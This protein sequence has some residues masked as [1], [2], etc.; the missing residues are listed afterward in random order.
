MR[1]KL[2]YYYVLIVSVLAINSVNS[3]INYSANFNNDN[4]NWQSQI[5]TQSSVLPCDGTGA[6]IGNLYTYGNHINATS[7][8]IGISNGG[9]ISLS[10]KY[11]ILDHRTREVITN[12]Q[13]WGFIK[14]Y[15]AITPMGPFRLLQTI[16]PTNHIASQDCASKNVNFFAPQGSNVF[17]RVE[18]EIDNMLI[19]YDVYI[20]EVSITQAAPAMCSGIPEESAIVT[21]S[22]AVGNPLGVHVPGVF[23]PPVLTAVQILETVMSIGEVPFAPI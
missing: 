18:A 12:E 2:Q 11:K 3:Q 19:D 20:D 14:I 8:S 13:E 22:S 17:V 6:L 15:Y 1:K 21:S 4:E 5:F 16:D 10:Y 7:P 23:Q 9:E